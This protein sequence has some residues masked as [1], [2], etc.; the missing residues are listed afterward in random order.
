[1]KTISKLRD[2]AR[3]NQREPDPGGLA[4]LYAR[5]AMG[6]FAGKWLPH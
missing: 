5:R 1:M 3:V 2:K 4:W 6:G